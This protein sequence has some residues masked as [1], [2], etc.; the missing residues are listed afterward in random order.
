MGLARAITGRDTV[1]TVYFADSSLTMV[2]AVLD[3]YE[4]R[5]FVGAFRKAAATYLAPKRPPR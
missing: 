2:R 1:I 4:A 3:S 5:A